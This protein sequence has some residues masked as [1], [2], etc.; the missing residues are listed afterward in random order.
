MSAVDV[1]STGWLK[2]ITLESLDKITPAY[3]RRLSQHPRAW[4][5]EIAVE[6]PLNN[7]EVA[8]MEPSEKGECAMDG[9]EAG[10]EGGSASVID[11][12]SSIV[13]GSVRSSVTSPF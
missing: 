10:H 8:P 1:S 4:N 13:D 6:E 12:G 3:E 11:D 5:R 7:V 2:P 9:A